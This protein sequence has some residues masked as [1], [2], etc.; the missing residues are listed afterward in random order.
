MINKNLCKSLACKNGNE[1]IVWIWNNP[2][3]RAANTSGYV[4]LVFVSPLR[5]AGK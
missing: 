3:V 4:T 2:P 5:G 1:I